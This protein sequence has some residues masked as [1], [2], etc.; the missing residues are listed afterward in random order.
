MP[1][2]CDAYFIYGVILGETPPY[3]HSCHT[4]DGIDYGGCSRKSGCLEQ[5]AGLDGDIRLTNL[6]LRKGKDNGKDFI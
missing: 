1:D 2:A 3:F 6:Y 5:Q 4:T